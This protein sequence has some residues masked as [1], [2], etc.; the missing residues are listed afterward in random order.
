MVL[1]SV[2]IE[3]IG[4]GV[5]PSGGTLWTPLP[6][7]DLTT[8]A[9]TASSVFKPRVG[10]AILT[11][12]QRIFGGTR[13]RLHPA[14]G[15]KYATIDRVLDTT[16]T[17][18]TSPHFIPPVPFQSAF[19]HEKSLFNGGGPAVQIDATSTTLRKNLELLGI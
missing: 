14:M 13:F 15:I 19:V 11:L 10:Q 17:G 8:Q 7:Y 16:Y 3:E 2:A 1:T 6:L 18:I 5:A 12:G 9:L 4:C